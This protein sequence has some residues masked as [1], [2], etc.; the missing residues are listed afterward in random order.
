[1]TTLEERQAALHAVGF[2]L[3][4]LRSEDVLID[5][6]TDS[7]HRR[8]VER[9]VGGHPAR[10]RELRRLA[11][12]VP[13]PGGRPGAVP[14]RARDPHPPG[15]GRREDPVHR[16]RRPGQ[17]HPEQHPLRHHA[18]QRRGDGSGGRRPRD[19]GGARPGR[20]AP[21]QG[22]HGP[23]SP[24]G[25]PAGASRRRA[26]GVRDRHQQLRRRS[27]RVAG[28]PARRACA[29]RS[30]RGAAVP[31]RLP[32]RR[33][34]LVHQASASPATPSERSPTSCGRWRRWP[35]A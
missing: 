17:G 19:R 21:V 7:G 29:L 23:R 28:E 26:R 33:E 9:P 4:G 31:R 10:R 24:R 13:V 27:A 6:L 14:V 30:L 22:E 1:M 25:L 35:T 2:N 3:F 18:G 5:L 11:V 15:A 34:R 20:S 32:L 8:D 12:L 16:H